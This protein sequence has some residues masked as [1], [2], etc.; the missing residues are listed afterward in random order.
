MAAGK[1]V[2]VTGATGKLRGAT[3]R[4]VAKRRGFKLWAATRKPERVGYSADSPSLEARWG[5]RPATL[6]QWAQQNR[7]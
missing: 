2:L 7:R 5:I 4:N 1:I 3:L 6:Q